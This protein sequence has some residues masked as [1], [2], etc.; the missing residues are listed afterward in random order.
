MWHLKATGDHIQAPQQ[1]HLD[2]A[3]DLGPRCGGASVRTTLLPQFHVL[4]R[5]TTHTDS[6]SYLL[7]CTVLRLLSPRRPPL[8]ALTYRYL[9]LGPRMLGVVT[10]VTGNLK[11]R[12]WARSHRLMEDYARAHGPDFKLDSTPLKDELFS[13]LL[14]MMKPIDIILRPFQSLVFDLRT[15]HAGCDAQLTDDGDVELCIRLHRYLFPQGFELP[16]VNF[17]G[18]PFL[19]T[20]PLNN[21]AHHLK[22]RHFADKFE[23]A[24][25]RYPL[26]NEGDF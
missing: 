3:L 21:L 2:T 1:A 15:L 26:R 10:A 19:S 12:L 7:A 24:S 4:S 6:F 23:D 11:I 18:R 9:P 8:P 25:R 14:P 16:T 22:S 13:S 20:N 17:K 5:G